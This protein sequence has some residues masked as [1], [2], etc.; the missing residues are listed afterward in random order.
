MYSTAEIK[1]KMEDYKET[2]RTLNYRH[3]YILCPYYFFQL[4]TLWFTII[5]DSAMGTL[6]WPVLYYRY[7]GALK[8]SQLCRD[9]SFSEDPLLEIPCNVE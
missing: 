5:G 6:F 9:V 8:S 7:F 2:E 1:F 3:L 4:F